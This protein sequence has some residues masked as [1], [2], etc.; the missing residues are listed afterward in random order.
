MNVFV[1]LGAKKIF[2]WQCIG[3][4]VGAAFV[5]TQSFTV[6]LVGVAIFTIA[7]VG[8]QIASSLAVDR[9]GV[10]P[11]GVIHPTLN[12]VFAAALAIAAVVVAV[13]HRIQ[14]GE[15]PS[16]AVIAALIVGAAVSFQH[17]FNG[18]VTAHAGSPVTAAVI[19][20]IVGTTLLWLFLGSNIALGNLQWQPLPAGPIYLYFGGIFGLLF[21]ITASRVIKVLGS[22]RFAMGSVT[23]QLI[24]SLLLDIFVPTQGADVSL[25]LIT[26][27]VMTAGAV[28]LAN[29]KRK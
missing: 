29:I 26:G 2:W 16:L 8:G 12:R 15:I 17:S 19:N 4:S 7:T 24:G 22:L 11:Q 25:Q 23:G 10:G 27:V 18:H 20:F 6:P 1:A 9:L 5:A 21:I 13:S 3:G 28:V 14:G